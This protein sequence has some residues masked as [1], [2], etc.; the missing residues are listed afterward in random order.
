MGYSGF[1]LVCHGKSTNITEKYSQLIYT[2]NR[3][4]INVMNGT[5][6]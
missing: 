5:F 1:Y 6:K 2:K 3:N 4:Y